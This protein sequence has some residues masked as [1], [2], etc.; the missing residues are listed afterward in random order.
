MLSYVDF[1]LYLYSC[2]N[3]PFSL[4]S[5]VILLMLLEDLPPPIWHIMKEFSLAAAV[6]TLSFGPTNQVVVGTLYSSY[7][8]EDA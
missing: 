7:C 2:P 3:N 4:T 8:G 1:V 5:I 6:M